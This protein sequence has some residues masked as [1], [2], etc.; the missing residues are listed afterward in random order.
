MTN[1]NS[2]MC[3][4]KAQLGLLADNVKCPYYKQRLSDATMTFIDMLS[5]IE[6]IYMH[7]EMASGNIYIYIYIYIYNL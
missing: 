7:I 2:K 4:W 1:D 6:D 5:K 3:S